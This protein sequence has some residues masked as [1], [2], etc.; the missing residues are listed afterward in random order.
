[1]SEHVVA[2]GNVAVVTGAA[3]GIGAALASAFAAAGCG[4]VLADVEEGALEQA[5]SALTRIGADVLAV[6]TDVSDASAVERLAAATIERF[7]RVDVLCNNA[8]VS[9]FNLLADQTLADW[10]WVLDVNLWGVVHGVQTF[11]PIMRD[12]GSPAHIVNTSSIAGLWSG[13]PFIGPYAVSKVGVVSLSETL[14]AELQ[15]TASPIGVSVLCPSSVDTNVMEAERNRP[16][17]LGREARADTA[18]Q[19]RLMIRDGFT[20][21]DGKTPAEVAAITL[22]AIRND[23]FWIITHASARATIEARF[24]SILAD[25]PES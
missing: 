10:R 20:G 14:R 3:S 13:I 19:V 5:A 8:G 23:R 4:V 11:L 2:P 17:E 21:D 24:A 9:T 25:L 15:M 16:A 7:G 22:D 12:Q 6:P 1:M 18:E